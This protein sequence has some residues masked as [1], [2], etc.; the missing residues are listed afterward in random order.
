MKK[1]LLIFVAVIFSFLWTGNLIAQCPTGTVTASVSST[2]NTCAGNGTVTV[3]FSPTTGVSLQLLKSGSILNQTIA[4][5]SPYTWNNLQAGNDYQVKVICN[6]DNTV[7]YQTLDVTVADNYVPISTADISVSNVCTNFTTEGTLTVNSVTGGNAPYQYS[8]YLSNDPSYDDALSSYGNS[9]TINVSAFGTYQIRVKDACGNYKTFTRTINPNIDKIVVNWGVEKVCNS[10]MINA[11][12]S[13]GQKG[14]QAL[15]LSDLQQNPIKLEIYEANSAENGPQGSALYNATYSGGTFSY[16]MA[17]SHKYWVKTTNSC[18]LVNE[19]L[20]NAVSLEDYNFYVSQSSSGC[21]A[22]EQMTITGSIPQYFTYPITVTIKNSSGG[23][24]QTL[25]LAKTDSGWT[26]NPLPMDTYTVTYTDACGVSRDRNVTNPQSAGTPILDILGYVNFACSDVGGAATQTGTVQVLVGVSGYLPDRANAVIKIISGPS[27]VGQVAF[28]RNDQQ[29]VFNNMLPGNYMVSIITSCGVTNTYPM[30]VNPSANDLLQQSLTSVG[31]SFCSGGGNILSTLVYNGNYTKNVQLFKLPNLTTPIAVHPDGN[32]YN[33]STGTYVTKL[34]INPWCGNGSYNYTI[35][36]STVTLT[37]SSTGPQITSSVGVVCEDSAGNPLS[38]GTAYLNLSGVAPFKI[39]YKKTSETTWTE[40][41]NAPANTSLSGLTANTLYDVRLTD[42]CGGSFST[43]VN[44]KTISVLTSENTVQPCYNSPYT[45]SMKY[46]AGATY[47]WKNPQGTVVSNTR[48]YPIANY[49]A[50]NN[51]TYICKI[52]WS[53]CVTR[54]VNVT[55]NGDLCGAPLGILD[56]IDDDFSSTPLSTSGGIAG[57][58]TNNDL[59]DVNPVDDS[60]INITLNNNGGITGATIDANGNLIVPAG[61]PQGTYTVT[62]TICLI[63]SPATCDTATAIVVINDTM[64]DAVLDI[65]QTPINVPVS[66]N[67]ITN[68]EFTGTATVTSAQFY[69]ASG[70]LT[71]L[72]IGTATP[73]FT[74][75]GVPA[76][77]MLLNANGTYT[78]TPATGFVGE[79]PVNYT[80]TNNL[81]STDSTTLTIKVI[82]NTVVGNDNPIAQHD[83]SFTEEGVSVSSTVLN[84]DSDPDGDALTVTSATGLTIGTATVVSGVNAAGTPVANAGTVQLNANG[85]YTYVPAAGFV[86]TVN[87]LPY[88]ISD[89]N[90]GTATANI[91]I[92]VVGAGS[93]TNNTFANDDANSAPKGVTMTGN[94]KTNDTDP[95]GNTTTVTA[96]T[97]F[98]VNGVANGTALTIGTATVIP[99]VGSVT[100]N[101]NGTYSFV[102]VATYVGTVVI[103]YTICDNGVPQACDQATLELTSLDVV[104]SIDAVLDINQTPINVPVSGNVI[105]NDEFTGTAT[106]T[107][108]QFYNASGVLTNL[109]I[110]TATPVFT[111]AGVP[112]GT[113]LLNANGTYTYTPATGFVGEIPVNY[114]LTN[115]LGSTDST[116]LTIKVIPNTVVG[117]DNPIAQHDTS[118]TEEGVSVSSTVLN[119]DSDPDGDALTVTSATGLTIG[120]AT[121]V[122]GV[123]AAGTP[124]ANAGTVQLNANGTYT[125]V[126]AAG[127]VGTVNPLPYVISD[128]N[129]GTATA[130]IYITVVGAGSTTNNTFANDDANSAPKGVTMTGNV[131]TND[132]DPEGNTTTVTAATVFS[133][134]GVANGTALTIGTAT[135]IPGVGSVTLNANGTYSFVPVAT[136][137]GT[138]VIPYTICDNGVPQACDQATLEL[139]SLDIVLTA[140]YDLPNTATAGVDTKHGITILQRAGADNGNWP[141][142]RKSAHT[143]LESNTKGFVI[144]R[145]TTAEVTAIVSPQEGM[146]VYDTTA[147]CL[148]LYDGT[149]WSCFVTPTC[150]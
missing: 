33:L 104:D 94:V 135:V 141:M 142:I 64:L 149:A 117:N 35:E 23:I 83:T 59:F 73:V 129:G 138:V 111:P 101:A 80:L 39:E 115:N 124:V 79:I 127:F 108:A 103:P 60:N 2:A 31:N 25:S 24:V 72:P 118:F 16:Q 37:D 143:A 70:V 65:N 97:V 113:M 145:M 40:M 55:V 36:G 27:N 100:L 133:V 136:Y 76:G 67:V 78:Y 92:T 8:A 38:T 102:P 139:T 120:T 12:F 48:T 45:L 95:E 93:T 53:N 18:G 41:N 4:T 107:S 7:V 9:N 112:A 42:A 13:G 57:D 134:N 22:S 11:Q 137:V 63:S 89:G 114:T 119:N 51:G 91:Y 61:T 49:T 54:Y 148:K 110:G 15:S 50:A 6:A 20:Y 86:G 30:I 1:R 85:T 21:G 116:T 29:W 121:V 106:V 99:G 126:P 88:V 125:Y 132:T 56:A 128:G 140:C 131:K 66:G 58:L 150:P 68:D 62:Y 3:N 17:P 74:P 130:N 105:T 123:N 87:P 71:N 44:V 146:M 26:S 52:T 84:N 122:S 43:T 10:N 98:S 144:T 32:F 47:E 19:Y 81:G 77:T 75:A 96:A 34:F 46:Y 109:P 82:P 5:S 90:G 69:N 28:V 147:K 14:N